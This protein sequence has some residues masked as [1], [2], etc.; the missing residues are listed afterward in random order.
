M[1]ETVYDKQQTKSEQNKQEA[2]RT[3]SVFWLEL[4]KFKYFHCWG[5]VCLCLWSNDRTDQ[6]LGG[7]PSNLT[8]MGSSNNSISDKATT[9]ISGARTSIA[10]ITT[11][12][13]AK[14][15]SKAATAT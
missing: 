4:L 13:A 9:T 7:G 11:S 5:W 12:I 15:T 2:S 3:V 10:A 8:E 6:K 1:M 14:T